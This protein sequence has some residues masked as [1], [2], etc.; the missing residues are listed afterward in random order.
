M[1]TA[2]RGCN[3]TDLLGGLIQGENMANLGGKRA[4]ERRTNVLD[5]YFPS[6]KEELWLPVQEPGF[7]A[8]PRT[9]GLITVL[10]RQLIKG[11]DASRVYLDLWYRV[12]G[13]GLVEVRE[14]KEFAY[15][16]GLSPTR[17]V[18]SWRDRVALLK[19]CGFIK[20]AKRWDNEFYYIFLRHPDCV[21]QEL[22]RDGV[23][24]DSW[25]HEYE[26]RKVE[27]GAKSWERP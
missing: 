9:L 25:K 15:S 24:P 27:I 18:R 19:K 23:V 7:I 26:K 4:K 21:V 17:G 22:D 1:V 11:E 10:I 20:T 14:E 8:A 12:F 13:E 5:Q 16:S 6:W 2:T 3:L